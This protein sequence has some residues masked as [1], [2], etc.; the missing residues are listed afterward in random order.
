MVLVDTSVWIEFLRLKNARLKILLERGEIYGHPFV[1]GEL[2]CG[3]FVRREEILCLLRS[4]PQAVVA[5]HEEAMRFLE[6]HRLMGLG[7]G[8]VD[9]HLLASSRLT[10]TPLWTRDHA[11]ARAAGRLGCAFPP[12]S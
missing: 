8:Y 6:I 9:V 1:I 12:A 11:L 3:N 2:A 7:L 10:G 4:L 5:E